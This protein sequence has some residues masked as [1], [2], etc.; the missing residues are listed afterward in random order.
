MEL[1][2]I[3]P[4]EGGE[5]YDGAFRD[6]RPETMIMYRTDRIGGDP[7]RTNISAKRERLAN[8]TREGIEC[9]AHVPFENHR[10]YEH[11]SV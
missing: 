4:Y 9:N 2:S 6:I 3:E 8:L 7:T 10:F 11:F 1:N 5:F